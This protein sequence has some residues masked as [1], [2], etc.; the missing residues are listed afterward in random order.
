MLIIIIYL[1][2][3]NRVLAE[4]GKPTQKIYIKILRSFYLKII[5]KI[6]NRNPVFLIKGILT[7][8]YGISMVL[9]VPRL[10]LLNKQVVNFLITF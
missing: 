3:S 7:F 5:L 1:I 9:E 2:K 6:F 10:K 8:L 4:M